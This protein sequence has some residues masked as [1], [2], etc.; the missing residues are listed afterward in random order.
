MIKLYD[1][2]WDK[3]KRCCWNCLYFHIPALVDYQSPFDNLHK[4]TK[5]DII[6]LPLTGYTTNICRQY[7]SR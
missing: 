2:D 6:I 1:Q 5:K 4:C 3:N 7:I